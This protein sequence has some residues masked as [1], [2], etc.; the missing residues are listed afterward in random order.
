[1]KSKFSIKTIALIT[2]KMVNIN[3]I[4]IDNKFI[5]NTLIKYITQKFKFIMY[6]D[7]KSFK[8]INNKF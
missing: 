5:I 2:L 4:S 7:N 6:Y 8:F 1:M 3:Y